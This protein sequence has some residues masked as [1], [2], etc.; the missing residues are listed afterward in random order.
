MDSWVGEKPVSEDVGLDHGG[1]GVMT[2]HGVLAALKV[3]LLCDTLKVTLFRNCAI[4]ST[5]GHSINPVCS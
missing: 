2:V 4:Q 5:R 1:Q 3:A